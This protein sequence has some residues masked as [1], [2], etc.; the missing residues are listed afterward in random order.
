MIALV[1]S[2]VLKSTRAA[3]RTA[4]VKRLS[5][6]PAL[7]SRR[8]GR[9]RL[10]LA[11]GTALACGP[12]STGRPIIVGGNAGCGR[13]RINTVGC[14]VHCMLRGV[15]IGRGTLYPPGAADN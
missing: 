8:A 6:G 10:A 4:R 9:T 7:A 13:V 1:N 5:S 15:V 11:R 14:R 3:H 12:A 2:W